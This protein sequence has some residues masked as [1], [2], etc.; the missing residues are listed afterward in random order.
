MTLR[1]MAA[2]AVAT[3]ERA[4][5]D[6]A[7]FEAEL[8]ARHASGAS[9]A[10]YFAAAPA[11]ERSRWCF[12][13]MV[14]R[15]ARREP[16]AYI[17]GRREFFGLDIE[18]TPAVLVPRPETERLVELVLEELR[19]RA[20]PVVLDVGTG[21]GCIAAAIGA[22]RPDARLIATEASGAALAVAG[23]NCARL[24]PGVQL[25]RG[26]LASMTTGADVVV[27]NLPYVPSARIGS[28]DPE[29]R[30]W[31][32]RVALD[33]GRDGTELIRRLIDD[34]AS[35][36]RPGLLVLEADAPAATSVACFAAARGASVVVHRDLAGLDRVV[37]ARW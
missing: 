25:I 7:P 1:E 13:G 5:I 36:L 18:V 9:R 24:A 17:T 21:S 10:A 14:E 31:E 2:A 33:G 27:A 3:L 12:R 37:A 28:L 34:C 35:R 11:D 30:D 22:N 16:L 6:E 32:P 15:R 19:G 26:D 29:V 20:A 23:R 8:L 4:G